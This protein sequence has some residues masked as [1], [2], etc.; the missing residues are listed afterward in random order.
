MRLTLAWF[1]YEPD[2]SFGPTAV[3]EEPGEDWRG[4]CITQP[5]GFVRSPAPDWEDPGSYHQF[6]PEP[7]GEN[8]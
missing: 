3:D 8:P 7:D 5:V 2:F 6:D 4:D 1:G